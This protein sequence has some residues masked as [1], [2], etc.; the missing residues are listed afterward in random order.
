V[1]NVID[2]FSK[3]DNARPEPEKE[4]GPAPTAPTEPGREVKIML[5]ESSAMVVIATL[6]FYA[7][8]G[9]DGGRKAR[10]AMPALQELLATKG[11]NLVLPPA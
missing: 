10:M 11:V 1:S 2:L 6:A 3:R 4:I 5:T 7:Q 8:Q 9:W